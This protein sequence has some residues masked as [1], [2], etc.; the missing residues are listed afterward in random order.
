MAS[1]L[2]V[3]QRVVEV[4]VQ[5]MNGSAESQDRDLLAVEE[6]LEI[7]LGYGTAEERRSRS[8][9][10]TMRTPG[11]DIELAVGFLFAEGL[12]RDP[13]DIEVIRHCGSPVGALRLRNVLRVELK[14]EVDINT[15]R[16]NQNARYS[17]T[18]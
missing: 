5:R 14:S 1:L 9:T 17:Y 10:I 4:A 11:S 6:P 13:G 16:L 3:E 12:V 15:M 7:R 8:I 2:L 18:L